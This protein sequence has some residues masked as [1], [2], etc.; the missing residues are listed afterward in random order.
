MRKLVGTGVLVLS[1]MASN[2]PA[3]E[4]ES[5]VGFLGGQIVKVSTYYEEMTSDKWHVHHRMD[6]WQPTIFE[7]DTSHPHFR[8]IFGHLETVIRNDSKRETASETVAWRRGYLSLNLKGPLTNKYLLTSDADPQKR[9][10]V[11]QYNKQRWLE[12][13]QMMRGLQ[14]LEFLSKRE[15]EVLNIQAQTMGDFFE[16]AHTRI[17][18]GQLV[19]LQLREPTKLRALVRKQLFE[20]L[21]AEGSNACQKSSRKGEIY[22]CIVA[23]AKE[24]SEADTQL[25]HEQMWNAG[26]EKL[27]DIKKSEIVRNDDL[28]KNTLEIQIDTIARMLGLRDIKAIEDDVSYYSANS[29]ETHSEGELYLWF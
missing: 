19:R 15:K 25:E 6:Y 13:V 24:G 3:S 18:D 12:I 29:D 16:K 14:K 5:D 9:T 21:S 22:R 27:E 4:P 28:Q 2:L 1:T 7:I 8:K 26:L 23:D 17:P 20:A 10:M 11:L